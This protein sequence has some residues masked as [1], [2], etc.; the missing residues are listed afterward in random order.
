MVKNLPANTRDAC[1]I[2]G[3]G[4]ST[5]EG[6]GNPFQYSWP[7]KFHGQKNLMGY[8]PWGR[9]ELDMT[10][11]THIR[12]RLVGEYKLADFFQPSSSIQSQ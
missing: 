1:S 2:P 6:N 7:G 11:H 10:E 5:K 12:T 4:R 8:S 9:K 3:L